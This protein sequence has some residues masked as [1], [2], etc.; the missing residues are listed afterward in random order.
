M[1]ILFSGTELH[2]LIAR[3][4]KK[5][6]YRK[7]LNI[8]DLKDRITSVMPADFDGDAQNDV[9]ITRQSPDN[10]KLVEIEI[11]WGKKNDQVGRYM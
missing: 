9:L 4:E 10:D 11:Y 5:T 7:K 3:E 2:V 8:K 6:F 1:Y